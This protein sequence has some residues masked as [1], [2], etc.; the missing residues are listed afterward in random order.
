VTQNFHSRVLLVFVGLIVLALA[1]ATAGMYVAARRTTHGLVDQQLQIT[2]RLVQDTLGAR[3]QE[4]RTSLQALAGDFAFREAVSSHDGA[5]IASALGNHGARV[6]ADVAVLL[7]NAGHIVASTDSSLQTPSAQ[8]V[9]RLL[10]AA[11]NEAVGPV[12]AD[13][14]GKLMQL[15]VV[16]IRAPDTIGWVGMGFVMRDFVAE[17]IKAI[18][19]TDVTLVARG[20]GGAP[21]LAASTLAPAER[22][23]LARQLDVLSRSGA[24]AGL[25]E[26]QGEAYLTK[27]VVVPGNGGQA[28]QAILQL[29]EQ[30]VSAPLQALRHDL[31]WWAGPVTSVALVAAMLCA[32]FLA[33]PVQEL[34]A[35]ARNLTITKRGEDAAAR[36]G[37]DVSSIAGALQ[38]L[39]HRTQYDAL[40]G[41]PNRTLFAEWLAAGISRAERENTPLAVVFVDLEGF[42]SINDNMGRTIGDLVLRKTAQ[43]LLRCLR[44]TDVVARLGAD[45]F[46]LILDG[47]SQVGALKIVERLMP[48]V[49]KPMESPGGPIRVSMRA[50]IA[51][52]PDHARDRERLLHLADAAR[53][54]SKSR[55][56]NTAVARAPTPDPSPTMSLSVSSIR[57]GSQTGSVST[58]DTWSGIPWEGDDLSTQPMKKIDI[59][60][61][62][63]A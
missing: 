22:S 42:R 9:V 7:D 49:A 39:T 62:E 60:T 8:P 3:D 18:S 21:N 30:V 4:Y 2:E 53:H 63:G 56:Q 55:K 14:S 35:A 41:L 33:R 12:V 5:T 46:V 23:A 24:A 15:V 11:R 17:Q 10:A 48:V 16:P 6:G 32:R 13:Y 31:L 34:A 28:F 20:S 37:D 40:T 52:Y 26:L 57:S 38:T 51:V 50:G 25:L 58:S 47:V 27:V 43:R 19:G 61:P 54:E 29:P 1:G 59:D 44:P 36:S 45:E